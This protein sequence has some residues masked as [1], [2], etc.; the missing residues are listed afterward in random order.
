MSRWWLSGCDPWSDEVEGPYPS[1]EPPWKP[2]VVVGDV[3]LYLQRIEEG[4]PPNPRLVKQIRKLQAWP[5]R[6][7]IPSDPTDELSGA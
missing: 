5:E 1:P 3:G 2:G 6:E 4:R 7:N